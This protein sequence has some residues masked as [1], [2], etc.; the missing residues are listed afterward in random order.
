MPEES[1]QKI[2]ASWCYEKHFTP[3]MR[4]KLSQSHKGKTISAETK[5]KISQALKGR[6]FSESHRKHLSEGRM[7]TANP[8]YG[9]AH[10]E[11]RNQMM[12]KLL[13]GRVFSEE[14]LKRMSEVRK[15]RFLGPDNHFF[16]R[17]H[18]PETKAQLSLIRKD[19]Y[20]ENPELLRR[21]L[22]C[23]KPNIAEQKLITLIEENNLPFKYVGDGQ[24]IL[25][26]KCP[27][28]LNVN[29]KKQIIEL[30][31]AYWHPIFDVAK[32]TEHFKQYGFQTLIIWEDEL[33]DMSK[34][35]AKI[36]RFSHATAT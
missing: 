28:F 35:S 36:K 1:K 8:F 25:G 21:C 18:S 29:G 3:E 22:T 5:Q 4:V 9:H 2:Q 7:G 34:V 30:F 31:G 14:S 23:Q 15:G 12:S 10:T 26:G 13:T 17:H 32:R 27:D 24:F 11:K 16:G 33:K 6:T 20:A 19:L